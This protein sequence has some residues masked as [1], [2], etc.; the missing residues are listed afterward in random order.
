MCQTWEDEIM[1]SGR[2]TDYS[3]KLAK[4]ICD[5]LCNSPRGLNYHA[6]KNSHWPASSTIRR[7]IAENEIFRDMY[8]KAKQEQADFMFDEMIDVAYDDSKDHK[9]IIDE[10]GHEK[11]IC[12]SEMVNRSRLKVDTLKHQ[13]ER[14]NMRK[15][16][17]QRNQKGNETE[18]SLMQKLID[19]L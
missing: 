16:G 19:K 2:P 9:V 11:I 10:K 13:T 18:Q 15:Y 6:D 3:E 5:A 1:L 8:A 12:V 14:L 17:D 7:W 4:E